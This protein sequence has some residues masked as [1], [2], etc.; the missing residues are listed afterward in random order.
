MPLYTCI[1]RSGDLSPEQKAVLAGEIT[2]VHADVTG[3]PRSFVQVFF[4]EVAP[5][6]G[7]VGGAPFAQASIVGLIRAGR[8][9]E[10]K[11][12]LL[13]SISQSWCQVTGQDE[14]E[15]FIGVVDVPAKNIMEDGALLP[16]PGE[17]EAWVAEHGRATRPA[18]A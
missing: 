9:Q 4:R 13:L 17:E 2:R 1:A 10:D 16:E 5:G 15:V 6:D 12:K 3:A 14:R 18:P 11:A 8:T 7:F